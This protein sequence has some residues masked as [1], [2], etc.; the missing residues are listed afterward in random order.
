[1]GCGDKIA[2]KRNF[3]TIFGL[4]MTLTFDLL[5]S[6]FNQFILVANSF[7]AVNLVKFTQCKCGE[8]HPS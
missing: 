6:K 3:L 7:K 4:V 5:N 1:M 8:I 2:P